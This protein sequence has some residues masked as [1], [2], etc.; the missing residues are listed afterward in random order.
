MASIDCVSHVLH[1]EAV[2]DGPGCLAPAL[3]QGHHPD[4]LEPTWT[5]SDPTQPY[6]L[7]KHSEWS[8]MARKHVFVK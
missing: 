2:H 8:E 5:H 6:F 1:D 7:K 3:Q 4:P